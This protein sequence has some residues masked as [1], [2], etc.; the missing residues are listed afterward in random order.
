MKKVLLLSVTAILAVTLSAQPRRM[1]HPHHKGEAVVYVISDERNSNPDNHSATSP[2]QYPCC[3]FDKKVVERSAAE[4]HREL[5]RK[6]CQGLSMPSI[7]VANKRNTFS[8]AIG[9]YVNMRVGYNIKNVVP[10][11]DMIP[12]NIPIYGDYADR[13]KLQV[14][15]TTTRLYFRG[16]ANTCK[17]GRVEVFF[18]AD[19]R[20]GRQG[21][22]TPGLRSAYVSLLGLTMGR[23]YTTFC[24][25]QSVPATV[26]YAGPNA[27]NSV[28]ATVIR[29]EHTFLKDH[30]RFGVAAELPRVSG[31][32]G[33]YLA[34]IP[35]RVPDFPVYLQVMWGKH[36]QSHF[37]VS[38]VFRDMYL[39]NLSTGSNVAKF[40]WGV[41]A[42][43][44]I[45]IGKMLQIF[46]NGVY[47]KGITPYMKDLVG[48][49][50]D[51]TPN[52]I[53]H[54]SVQT[55]PMYGWQAAAQIN[56]LRNLFVSGGYS[57]VTVCKHNGYYSADQ[58]RMGQYI[59]GNIFYN[60][61]M[62]MKVA[63][64]Y[65]WA[66]RKDMVGDRRHTNRINIMA[67][68]SF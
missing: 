26:D 3:T 56:I 54:R 41:Q 39:H 31:T 17:L 43:G 57:A 46:F 66:S 12:Y 25:Q 35:Q 20:G 36:R 32:Y 6:G 4:D 34:P 11:L 15:A 33:E 23:D 8:F 42:S 68:Y 2:E 47:G 21:S 60:I 9:G 19:F 65:L 50:L 38:A 58:Y 67:Q 18:D 30:M 16:V 10:T 37:R 53:N 28:F 62:R 24:D 45:H 63:A 64:E 40:G 51:F 49:G 14:D 29:Y 48:S 22:Y 52:P 13:Q 61:T 59:F 7:I 55:M 44:N 5:T 27:T 1:M